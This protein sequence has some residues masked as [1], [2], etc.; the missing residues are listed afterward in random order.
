MLLDL[1]YGQQVEVWRWE[2][3]CRALKQEEREC[4]DLYCTVVKRL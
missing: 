1:R 2:W 4:F 3:E